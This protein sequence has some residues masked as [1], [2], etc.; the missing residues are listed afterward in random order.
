MAAASYRLQY[1]WCVKLGR[2]ALATSAD[3]RGG[4]SGSGNAALAPHFLNAF[5]NSPP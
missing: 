3:A 2:H 4:C 5:A 1:N